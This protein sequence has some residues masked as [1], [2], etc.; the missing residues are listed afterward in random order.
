METMTSISGGQTS[1]YLAANYPTK[2][3]I[4]ALVTTNDKNCIYP[5]KKTRQ[6]VS[7]KI[8]RDFIGTLEDDKIINTILDLEQFIGRRI[9][10]VAGL[11]FDELIKKSNKNGDYLPNIAKRYCTTFLKIDPIFNYWRKNI[12]KHVLMNIGYRVTE[13]RRADSMQEK[14]NKDGLSEY[15]TVIGKHNDG[16]NK[17]ASIAWRR[18]NFPLI[19]DFIERQDI[20]NFWKNKPVRFAE[21]NNCVGCFHRSAALLKKMSN[22]HPKKFDWFIKE[23]KRTGNKFK[24]NVTYQK[25]KDS[26]FTLSIPFDYDPEGCESG[27]CGI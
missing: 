17:W 13:K 2:Y 7:D 23:E 6:L 11:T 4:F 12:N 19:T 5:D 16:R 1:A 14:L 24:K 22:L 8:G 26:N 10:W 27:F 15:K 18:P 3:N 9:D 21:L 20:N 25:I